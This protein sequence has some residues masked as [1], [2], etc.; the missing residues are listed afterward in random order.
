MS[1]TKIYCP[2][3]LRI[4]GDTDK[5]IDC[6]INCPKCRAQHIRIDIKRAANFNDYLLKK[7]VKNGR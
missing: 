1:I 2:S 6:V 3:C 7:E 5:S 4:L